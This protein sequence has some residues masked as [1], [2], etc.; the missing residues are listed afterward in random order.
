MQ[1]WL[2]AFCG[3]ARESGL[4]PAM[5]RARAEEAI[6]RFEG[7]LVVARVLGT[8]PHSSVFSKCFPIY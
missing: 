4:P 2:N 7:S 6:V 5:A 1:A 8:T 3:V